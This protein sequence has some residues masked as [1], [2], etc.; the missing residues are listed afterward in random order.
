VDRLVVLDGPGVFVMDTN[1]SDRVELTDGQDLFSQQPTWAPDGSRVAWVEIA[2]SGST[3]VTSLVDGSEPTRAPVDFAPFYMSWDPTSSLVAFLGSGSAGIE[4]G[5]VDVG[6]G[7][8]EAEILDAGEP[9]YFSWAPEGDR[10]IVHVGTDRLEQ[11]DLAGEGTALGDA[12]GVFQ[13]PQW[14]A[15]GDSVLYVSGGSDG[16]HLVLSNPDGS[17][18][19]EILDFD[20]FLSFGLSSDGARIAYRAFGEAPDA[21]VAGLSA[22][23]R[24]Q[25]GELGVIELGSEDPNIIDDRTVLAFF[26]SPQGDQLLFLT[27]ENGGFNWN[28]WDGSAVTTFDSFTPS[29]VFGRNYL[30]FFDQYSQSMTL[31]APDGSAF[32]Y[33]GVADGEDGIWVQDLD[34]GDPVL[35]GE[36]QFASWSPR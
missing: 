28:V 33:A 35:V 29:G 11:L 9:Y 30:P 5:I 36:G 23:P 26:W 16:Q 14:S 8:A 19:Q 4:M 13:A 15:G 6:G 12:P 17:A 10:M 27:T 31:W 7:G 34:G 22:A 1:G 21:I 25:D 24:A 18:R 20:G 3:L 32:T 2:N